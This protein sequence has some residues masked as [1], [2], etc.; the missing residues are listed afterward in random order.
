[1]LASI[2]HNFPLM[3]KN[4]KDEPLCLRAEAVMPKS[5]KRYN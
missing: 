5:R 4:T 1:M 3:P 2:V